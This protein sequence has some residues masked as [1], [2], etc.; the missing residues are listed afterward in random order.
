MISSP[1]C[2]GPEGLM[3]DF[4]V[5]A[6][7]RLCNFINHKLLASPVWND[8][9]GILSVT[10]RASALVALYRQIAAV[11]LTGRIV[12]A[13]QSLG[14]QSHPTDPAFRKALTE[15]LRDTVGIPSRTLDELYRFSHRAIL[16]AS[17]TTP[18]S[19]LKQLR[20]W[21]LLRH[22]KCYICGVVLDFDTPNLVN[23]YT[24]EHIWPRAYGGDG[25]EENLLPACDS[26]N[27]KKKRHFATWVMPSV[28]S[29]LL[30]LNPADQRLREIEGSYKFSLHYRAAQMLAV[31]QR[32]SMKAAF[33][34][35]G[36]WTDIRLL[37][38][39][40]VAD[41]FNLENHAIQ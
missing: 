12:A 29:L 23:S 6:G 4:G 16:A 39:D 25:I 34:K 15:H 37:D 27:S 18:T 28:Q 19:T 33:L 3:I 1:N 5:T 36:P 9:N 38:T 40:D 30:V 2:V 41:Y 17:A 10:G 21:A 13:G 20:T 7:E 8:L 32:L 31:E 35:I 22:P 11:T 14:D 24:C 26:C